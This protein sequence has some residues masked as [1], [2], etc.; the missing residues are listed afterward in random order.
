MMHTK[1]PYVVDLKPIHGQKSFYGK[2]QIIRVNG[3]VYLRSYETIVCGISPAD[4]FVRLWRGYSATT[5]KHINAFI[6]LY[7]VPGGGKE[8]WN[9]LEVKF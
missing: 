1:I 8:W 5:M 6:R 4:K 7:G 3:W 9:S 2:A